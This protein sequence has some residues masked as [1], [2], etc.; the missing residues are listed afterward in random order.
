MC[1]INFFS[2]LKAAILFT[3]ELT[4]APYLRFTKTPKDVEVVAGEKFGLK[5]EAIGV[6]PPIIEW[7]F[8][9]LNLLGGT[10]QK[11]KRGRERA[12]TSDD[13]LRPLH[14]IATVLSNYLL[15]QC[16]LIYNSDVVQPIKE[17]NTIEKLYN[18][19][20]TTI[21]NSVT[22]SKLLIPCASR[23]HSGDYKCLASNGHQKLEAAVTVTVGQWK[24]ICF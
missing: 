24:A 14:V 9:F 10:H 8:F 5:C 2:S 15:A 20:I 13:P 12:E 23:E 1:L 4:E 17:M 7:S 21:Q 11:R 3:G 18:S 22:A 19:G 6:P 16:G